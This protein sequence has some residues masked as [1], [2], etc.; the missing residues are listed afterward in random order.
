MKTGDGN[1]RVVTNAFGTDLFL[2]RGVK[3]FGA[4]PP[5]GMETFFVLQEEVKVPSRVFIVH[6]VSH[7]PVTLH[8]Q[9]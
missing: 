4:L 5:S 8:V 1:A 9:A 6:V 3:W 2:C 7:E